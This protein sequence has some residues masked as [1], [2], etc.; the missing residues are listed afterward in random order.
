MNEPLL[1]TFAA[2][3][4]VLGG[5]CART[6]RRLAKDGQITAIKVRG[7]AFIVTKS[8]HDYVHKLTGPA[9]NDE[10]AGP[11][12]P[13]EETACHTDAKI[14][15]FSGSATRTTRAK[16]FASLVAPKTG[17]RPQRP[18]RSANSKSIKSGSGERSPQGPS[19]T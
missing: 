16:E 9:H 6:V 4:Q 8:L 18:K 7:R 3:G 2:A 13:E 12:V 17:K 1:L 14:V 11:G 19:R 10:C 5:L 15:Q